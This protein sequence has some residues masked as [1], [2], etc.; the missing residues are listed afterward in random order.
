MVFMDKAVKGYNKSNRKVSACPDTYEGLGGIRRIRAKII[1]VLNLKD[2]FILWFFIIRIKSKFCN[3]S[4][5]KYNKLEK[6]CLD[7]NDTC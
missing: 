1:Q 7:S 2:F 4:R 3:I 6:S 5:I